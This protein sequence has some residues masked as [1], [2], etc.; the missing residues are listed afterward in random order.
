MMENRLG[1]FIEAASKI[2]HKMDYV[3]FGNP[4]LLDE[5][6][7][8]QETQRVK[9]FTEDIHEAKRMG[10]DVGGISWKDISPRRIIYLMKNSSVHS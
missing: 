7:Q 4:G 8:E 10:D 9:W 6:T 5:L 1:R 2:V 3:V